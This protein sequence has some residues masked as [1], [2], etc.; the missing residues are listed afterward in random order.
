MRMALLDDRF[1][2]LLVRGIAV[3][4]QEQDR[5]RLHA[6]AHRVG[7]GGAHLPLVGST[8]TLPCASIRSRIS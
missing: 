3:G 7:H 6:L 5:D 8:N 1:R 4:V 2:A